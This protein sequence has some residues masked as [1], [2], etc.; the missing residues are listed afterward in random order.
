M[1]IKSII[2]VNLNELGKKAFGQDT[3]ILYSP[4]D[5]CKITREDVNNLFPLE[6]A[7]GYKIDPSFSSLGVGSFVIVVN[8]EG[9]RELGEVCNKYGKSLYVRLS[10][11]SNRFFEFNPTGIEAT[12]RKL[13]YHLEFASSEDIS[14]FKCLHEKEPFLKLL[15][16]LADPSG[17]AVTIDDR[18]V[19]IPEWL[20]ADKIS[21]LF[22]FMNY[23][24]LT[25]SDS[26]KL[27]IDNNS[28]IIF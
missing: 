22:D 12:H 3:K 18:N 27:D 15:H 23:D 7:T 25:E 21:R 10:R 28:D 16:F 24:I 20:T 17:S 11:I 13:K 6:L 4:D 2:T 1:T 14:A 5:V 26:A 19:V 9:K 8:P